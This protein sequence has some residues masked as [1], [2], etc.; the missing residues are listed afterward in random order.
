MNKGHLANDSV[1]LVGK[2]RLVG[3]VQQMVAESGDQEG[4]DAAAWVEQWLESPLPALGGRK[5]ATFMDTTD[6][7]AL[8]ATLLARMQTGAYS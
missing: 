7:Q 8:V 4:F 1:R 3:Q 2:A 5:P 6:G